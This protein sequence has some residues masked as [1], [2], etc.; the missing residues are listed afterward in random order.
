MK[1]ALLFSS[2]SQLADEIFIICGNLALLRSIYSPFSL[3]QRKLW[4]KS[5]CAEGVTR[6]CLYKVGR[7][8]SK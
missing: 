7:G 3:F 4:N 8:V 5:G 2:N 1:A 6:K